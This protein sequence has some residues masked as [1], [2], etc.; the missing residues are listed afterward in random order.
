MFNQIIQKTKLLIILTLLFIVSCNFL[1]F[2][3]YDEVWDGHVYTIP[4]LFDTELAE[5]GETYLIE[6]Y[7]TEANYSREGADFLIYP[8]TTSNSEL[9]YHNLQVDVVKNADTIFNKIENAFNETEEVWIKVQI[10]AK[11]KLVMIAGNGWSSE[12]FILKANAL[13]IRE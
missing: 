9:Q 11:T 8:E 10:R 2:Q 13:R 4:E 1:S 12:M 3:S 5:E 6:G 7:I